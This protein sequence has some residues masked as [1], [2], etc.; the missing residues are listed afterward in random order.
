MDDWAGDIDRLI[1][2]DGHTPEE[3]EPVIRWCQADPFWQANVRSGKKLRDK[4]DTLEAQMN[5]PARGTI[6]G[7][8]HGRDFSKLTSSVGTRISCGT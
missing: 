7:K 6:G 2:I 8:P 3:I 5:R 4:F 1:R